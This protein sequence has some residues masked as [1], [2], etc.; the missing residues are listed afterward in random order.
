MQGELR[1]E[2]REKLAGT[3][4]GSVNVEEPTGSAVS[5]RL[6]RTSIAPA[7]V[8]GPRL[9]QFDPKPRT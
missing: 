9:G 7:L 3:P 8:L 1:R 6:V 5:S 2:N 4:P